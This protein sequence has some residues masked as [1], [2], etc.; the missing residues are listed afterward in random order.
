[1]RVSGAQVVLGLTSA[2]R[3]SPKMPIPGLVV[4]TG[5]IRDEGTSY[6]YLSPARMVE[7]SPKMT[8]LLETELKTLP[9]P[10]LS[11]VV[12]TTDA[13]YRETKRQISNYA[14]AESAFSRMLSNSSNR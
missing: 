9:L 6:H 1:M 5:A 12:W 4:C 10:A 14:R 3:I 8:N 11:G 2:G 7:A 13:P